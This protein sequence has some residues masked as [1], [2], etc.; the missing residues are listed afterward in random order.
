MLVFGALALVANLSCLALLWRFRT[1]NINMSESISPAILQRIEAM[2]EQAK[3]D[4]AVMVDYIREEL[5]E[6]PDQN[7][8]LKESLAEIVRGKDAAFGFEPPGEGGRL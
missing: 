1:L 4:L 2:C 7:D 5:F 3:S 8:R 6:R